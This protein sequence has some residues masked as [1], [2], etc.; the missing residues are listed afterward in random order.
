MP[1]DDAYEDEDWYDEED[2]SDDSDDVETAHCPECR[3][4]VYEFTEKC[5]ACGYWLTAADRRMMWS[6]DS[7]PKWILITAGVI[8][9]VL[10]LGML[11]LRF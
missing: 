9:V 5:P 10:V 2:E 4:P 1:H 11:T 6:G 3:A 8:L 7:K